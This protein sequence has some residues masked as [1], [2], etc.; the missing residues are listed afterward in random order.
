MLLTLAAPSV[1]AG[2]ESEFECNGRL[3]SLGEGTASTLVACGEPVSKDRR[4]ER[5]PSD[6][7]NDFVNV[8]EWTYDR[9]PQS[10]VRML[11]FENGRL[12]HIEVGDYG[13]R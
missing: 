11:R 2:E 7:P 5:R 6:L 8:E 13:K 10:F 4:V 1:L 3:V 9:G 12:V